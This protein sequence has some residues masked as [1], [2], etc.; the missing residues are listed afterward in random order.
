MCGFLGEISTNQTDKENFIRLLNLS[1]H[2]GPDQQD[3]WKDSFC[4]LG[5]NRLAII[6]V[7]ENA[8][9][10][11]VSPSK[12]YVL[13]FNGEIYNY[14]ELQHKYAILDKDLRSQSDSEIL[15]HLIDK[16]PIKEFAQELNGM[17]AISIYDVIHKK[18]YLIRDFAGIKPLFYGI[19]KEGL[20]F[21]SQFD[22]IFCH[23]AFN[24]FKILRPEIMKEYFGLG[25]MHA[26][27][28]IYKDIFQVAPGE[29]ITYDLNK[30]SIIDKF[31]YFDWKTTSK[32][33]ET[34][35]QTTSIFGTI[36]SKVIKNQLQSDVPIATFLSGG[37]DSPLVT[38]YCK[39]HKEDITAFT[40]GIA[41]KE[42]NE[43]EIA[44]EIAKEL[45]VNHII[46]TVNENQLIG[47]IKEHFNYF[48]EPFGDYSS[49]PTYLIT[50]Q[51]KNHATVMISGDGGDELF[52]GYPRFLRAL[53]H[54][55]W[56]NLPLFIRKII[57]PFYRKIFKNTSSAIDIFSRFDQWTLSKQIHLRGLDNLISDTS[58]SKE[59][60][61]T[62]HFDRT[63][64]KTEAILAL[65][66]NEYY[67]H[68]QKVL[69]KVDLMSMGNSLE[70]RVPF[71]DKAVIHFSNTIE[72]KYGIT[73][74]TPKLILRTLLNRF[75][76]KKITSLPKKGFS[77]P[78]K[79]WLHNDLREDVLKALD[80][81][82]FYGKEHI[83]K[84]EFTQLIDDF[85]KNP[86]NGNEWGI[87]HLYAWQKW[88][89][90]YKLL[91]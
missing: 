76:G 37:I 35:A 75:V 15:A 36:F 88:S 59:L 90:N 64:N 6:D 4:Q 45:N 40:F 29:I 24:D 7:S 84:F 14:K 19:H 16:I 80:Y 32:N 65:K 12:N 52:W 54:H 50:K 53:Q 41:N 60:L 67:G 23:S 11:L 87:W 63:K 89:E 48:S 78:I 57:A 21:A 46:E 27:N 69:R 66:E 39:Q 77:V 79:N 86:S 44:T 34:D 73:H 61:Q 25:Y 85:Y 74:N 47:I 26:P 56:F 58:F 91:N 30:M 43:S 8:K 3:V 2:R 18:I 28:T 51:A 49:I 1:K 70:V 20:V 38:A 17:F 55:F 13:V 71:L 81:E 5:F 10:P 31:V 68:L 82:K 72:P 9:Q 83:N 22:Q 33:L 62:Y 42:Y